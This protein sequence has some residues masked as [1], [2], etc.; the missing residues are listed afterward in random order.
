M[1]IW[2]RILLFVHSSFNRL[3]K[4]HLRFKTVAAGNELERDCVDDRV[5]GKRFACRK[6]NWRPGFPP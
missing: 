4:R 2:L 1:F 6:S 5:V 3:M